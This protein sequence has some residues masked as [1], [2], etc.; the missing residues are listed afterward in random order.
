MTAVM[1]TFGGFP[2]LVSSSYFVLRLEL[3]VEAACDK[4]WHIERVADD[5][6]SASNE[7]ASGPSSG[8]AAHGRQSG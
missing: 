8:L 7:S 6:P 2:A 4:S 1:A 3:R 5:G